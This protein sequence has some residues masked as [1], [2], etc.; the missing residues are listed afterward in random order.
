MTIT[1]SQAGAR[2]IIRRAFVRAE[3]ASAVDVYWLER[4]QHVWNF[5][6]KTYVPALGTAIL[7]RALNSRA[8]VYSLKVLPD[9]PRSYSARGLCHNSLVPAARELGFSIRNTG[10]EPLNNQPFFRYDDIH[11]IER[12][13]NTDDLDD[14]RA[15][16]QDLDRVDNYGAYHALIAFMHVARS[17]A[18]SVNEVVLASAVDDIGELVWA[19]DRL[20]STSGMGPFVAQ[21]L[22]AVLMENF[23]DGVI[24]RRLNDPSRDWPGDVQ[25]L[26]SEGVV[27]ASLEARNK[28][29]T[30]SDASSFI[31]NC[32]RAGLRRAYI[33]APGQPVPATGAQAE[34]AW[35]EQRVIYTCIGSVG[36]A[37]ASILSWTPR[38]VVDVLADL[39]Q[40]FANRLAE[41][42]APGWGQREW[43]D[44]ANGF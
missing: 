26:D 11:E 38:D 16:L 24:S 20:R 3:D 41:I 30:R 18:A 12:V 17:P 31:E 32:G 21:A 7:A 4:V 9:N 1:F 35:Q 27:I 5:A 15:I 8:D 29:V 37:I 28:P 40:S 6:A 36:E 10:R 14:F 43:A 39:P 22:G 2:N 13:K 33:F 44:L 34:W 23:Y 25:G 19:L 42:E